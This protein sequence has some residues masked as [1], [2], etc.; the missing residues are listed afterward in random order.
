[1]LAIVG[2]DHELCHL[3]ITFVMARNVPQIRRELHYSAFVTFGMVSGIGHY[4]RLNNFL[5]HVQTPLPGRLEPFNCVY[6]LYGSALK[7]AGSSAGLDG[8]T[9]D[10]VALIPVCVWK[11][12]LPFYQQASS[13]IIGGIFAKSTF[14]KLE[15]CHYLQTMPLR[16]N[17]YDPFVSSRRSRDTKNWTATWLPPEAP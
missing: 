16:P 7:Q 13:L 11:D 3:L 8:W 10:E 9:G 4:H 6:E 17:T 12:L 14:A 5:R 1:M 2:F 15:K